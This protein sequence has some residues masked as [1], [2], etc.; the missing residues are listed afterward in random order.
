[1]TDDKSQSCGDEMVLAVEMIYRR[2][3]YSNAFTVVPLKLST[4]MLNWHWV[5]SQ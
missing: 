4:I 2:C 1:M 3:I 5:I